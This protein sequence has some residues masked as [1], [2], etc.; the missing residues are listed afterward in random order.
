MTQLI[1]I[2][3]RA[4]QLLKIHKTDNLSFSDV[5][6]TKFTDAHTPKTITKEELTKWLIN[7]PKSNKKENI[8]K[9]IDKIVYGV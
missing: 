4:Y 9:N 7:L 2:S 5:I 3:N 8:S 6:I 1:Q